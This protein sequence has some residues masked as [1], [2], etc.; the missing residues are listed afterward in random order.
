M[1]GRELLAGL[2]VGTTSVKALLVAP[3]GTEV[4][5]GRAPTPWAATSSGAETAAASITEAARAALA[6]AVDQVAGDRVVAIGVASMA[7]S[8]VLVGPDD[9][10]LAPVIAWHDHRDE[11]QLAD[12]VDTVGAQRFSARTGLP[13]WTQWS[14]T[15][16]RWLV[17]HVPAARTAVRRYNIAEWVAR[18]LGAA[19]VTEVSLASRT[20]WLDL[21]TRTAWSETMDWSGAPAVLLADL[22]SA[23]TPI[24]TARTSGRLAALDGATLTVAGHDHQA[25]VVGVGSSGAG[26]ELDS[27]GTAEAI[28]RTVAPGLPAEAV[29]ALT[30]AGVTVGWHAI[31]DRWCLLG[32][33]QGGLVLG[34]VQA[35]LGVDAGGLADLDAAALAAADDPTVLQISETAD[36]TVSPGADPGRIWRAA[37]LAVTG[38]ARDLGDHLDRA[39]GRRRDLVVAGG[40]TNSTAVMA[41]KTE[42]FGPLRRATTTEAGARGAAFLAGLAHGTYSA[43]DDIPN[44]ARPEDRP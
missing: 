13:V 28:L 39:A 27:C 8:G 25:A 7:E 1:T 6:D 10:P 37:V 30:D 38:Q 35:A 29:L 43:Y 16:Y 21:A 4:A 33:T 22:V 24:G 32:A 2:D 9:G 23:G 19:P 17:D 44:G 41:A 20:G 31:P 18:D 3:D 15:K 34:R 12:L 11:S 14:L 42:A 5:L 40:W 26:D 36:V